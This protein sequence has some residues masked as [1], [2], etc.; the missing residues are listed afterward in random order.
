M[1]EQIPCRTASTGNFPL[2]GTYFQDHEVFADDSSSRLPIVFSSECL[3]D[4]GK[5]IVYFGSSIHSITKGQTRQDIEDCYKKGYVCIRG[6]DRRTRSPRRLRAALHSINEK[7][8]DGSK[9]K[10]GA[11]L[12][13]SNEQKAPST[14]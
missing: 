5:C 10:E 2:N 11:G 14:N 13:K 3:N 8:E 4:L 1:N 6:F 9:H 7:K 12:G